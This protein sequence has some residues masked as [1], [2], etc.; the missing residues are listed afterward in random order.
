MTLDEFYLLTLP[1]NQLKGVAG[2]RQITQGEAMARGAIPPGKIKPKSLAQIA[3][4]KMEAEAK[5]KKK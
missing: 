4:E 5:A 1:E 3:R 2:R